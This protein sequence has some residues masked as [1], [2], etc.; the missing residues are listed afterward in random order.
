MTREPRDEEI[1]VFTDQVTGQ[2]FS[3]TLTDLMRCI[4]IA[5]ERH[6]LPPLNK[7]TPT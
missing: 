2:D 5:Q 7:E 1:I 6:L 3:L 4:E